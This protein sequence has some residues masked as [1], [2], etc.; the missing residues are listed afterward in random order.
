MC[1]FIH[2]QDVHL[3]FHGAVEDDIGFALRL[4]SPSGVSFQT[5]YSL[6]LSAVHMCLFLVCCTYV[7]NVTVSYD[8]P[9]A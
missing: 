9:Y 4:H 8:S 3:L 2:V 7:I 1:C 6:S 5:K